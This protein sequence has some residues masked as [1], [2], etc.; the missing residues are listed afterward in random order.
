LILLCRMTSDEFLPWLFGS[1]ITCVMAMDIAKQK[2]TADKG[3]RLLHSAQQREGRIAQSTVT[4]LLEGFCD[5]HAVI[6]SQL[7][8]TEPAPK[9]DVLTGRRTSLGKPFVDLVYLSERDDLHQQM[10][11]IVQHAG[12]DQGSIHL[13]SVRTYLADNLSVPIPVHLFFAFLVKDEAPIF[14]VG[15]CETWQPPKAGTRKSSR[16][17]RRGQHAKFDFETGKLVPTSPLYPEYADADINRLRSAAGERE[18]GMGSARR[19]ADS[20]TVKPMIQAPMD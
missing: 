6:D 19:R 13:Q 16:G 20:P 12:E 14:M 15:V 8:L 18:R 1:I 11:T 7:V 9:L 17:A 10:T 3:R 5:A 2:E 4:N